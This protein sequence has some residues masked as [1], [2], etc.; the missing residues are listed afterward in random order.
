MQLLVVRVDERFLHEVV[1]LM[2]HPIWQRE[3]SKEQTITHREIETMCSSDIL[4]KEKQRLMIRSII[5]RIERKKAVSAIPAGL[6][7]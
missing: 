7:M 6:K 5:S 1:V 3:N 2:L 4:T